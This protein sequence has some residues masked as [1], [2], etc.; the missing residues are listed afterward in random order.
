M[1]HLNKA[2]PK[3]ESGGSRAQAARILVQVAQGRSLSEALQVDAKPP[4]S[5]RDTAFVRALCY[6]VC[7]RYEPL[8]FYLQQLL[9]RPLKRKDADIKH[10]LMSAL[11]Q[12]ECMQTP[13]YAAVSAS[14]DAT[15]L[16]G[17]GWAGGMANAVL[18]R[19]LREKDELAE[20]IPQNSPAQHACP[21]WL[22]DKIRSVWPH[23]WENILSAWQCQPP[24]S[25][26]VNLSK[27]TRAD[28]MQQL[29]AQGIGCEASPLSESA[30]ILQQAQDVHVLPGFK[31]GAVSVQDAGAQLA[32]DLLRPQK[33]QYVLDACAAPG[34]KTG[35]LLETT[36]GDI[37]LTAADVS[38]KRIQ[39]ISQNLQRIGLQA[40]IKAIDLQ[41]QGA[42][43]EAS[44][45]CILLDAPCSASGVIQR[46]PDIKQLRRVTDI[47]SLCSQQSSLLQ[48]SWRWL[49]PDGRLLYVTCSVLPQENEEQIKRFLQ[50]HSDASLLQMPDF[51]DNPARLGLQLLPGDGQWDGFYYALLGKT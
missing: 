26:R 38:K 3:Q 22:L 41:R 13:S 19:Y 46:H 40:D 5:E 10:L 36:A 8:E 17:K 37:H 39:D 45:D 50:D 9:A 15:K 27:N 4:L 31:Q 29:Q 24:M 16:L 48:N 2:E 6:G 28:M 20:K 12:L 34:G 33:G 21:Q 35:H 30:I 18:R 47:D 32:A 43:S 49:K 44:F 23:H 1:G 42:F 14:V 11:F 25:L 51:P 7:R